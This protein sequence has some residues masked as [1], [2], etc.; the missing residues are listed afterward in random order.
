[1]KKKFN[2]VIIGGGASGLICASLLHTEFASVLLLERGDRVGKKLSATG[3]GQ[4]NVTNINFGAEHYFTFDEKERGKIAK[5]L[6]RH[7]EREMIS[8]FEFL[9]GLFDADDRGRVYPT[10]RQAS[11]ITD[12]LRFKLQEKGVELSLSSKVETVAKKDGEF[13]ITAQTPNGKEIFYADQVLLCAGGKASKN[14]G[15]DGTA[16]EL[17]KPFGHTVTSLYPSLVQVKTETTDSKPLK[18]IRVM[19]AKVSA[20]KNCQTLA[21]VRGDIIFTEYGVSGDAIFKLSSYLTEYADEKT[22]SLSIDLLPEVEKEKLQ[23]IIE[24]KYATGTWA[25]NELL[26]GVLNNQVGRVVMKRA[27]SLIEVAEGIKNFTL[28]VTGTLGF[29]YA[30]VTKGGI[31]LKEVTDELESKKVNGLYFSGEIL[32]VDGECGG[33]NLQWAYSSAKTVADAVNGKINGE[34]GQV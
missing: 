28:K 24:N 11:S 3:N 18:G 13:L 30:Q 1:M 8:Y 17:V 21:S 19:N 16:Y 4:G 5:I 29:D 22:V 25:Y 33:Y 31:P 32:D 9:G 6:E 15:T 27:K 26:C 20:I 34:R 7:N 14:F 2:V 12:L 10:G 23:R